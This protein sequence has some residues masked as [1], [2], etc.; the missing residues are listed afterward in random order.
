[1]A[2]VA[3]MADD[4]A[5]SDNADSP[6][7]SASATAAPAGTERRSVQAPVLATIIA[8]LIV[9][10]FSFAVVGFNVLR[11]DI[12]SIRTELRREIS[13]EIAAVRRDMEAGFARVDERFVQADERFD[14]I[15]TVLVDHTD[16]LARVETVL[17]DHTDR[18]ARVETVL[19]DHTDRLARIETVHGAHTHTPAQP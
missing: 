2:T 17:V 16:R 19:V 7:P 10:V 9:G 5:E 18:L 15:E 14:R 8:A 1:M 6:P 3:I 12:G 13:I 11:N 4:S